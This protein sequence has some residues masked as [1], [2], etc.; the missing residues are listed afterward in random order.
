MR[1]WGPRSRRH[2]GGQPQTRAWVAVV[3][4]HLS[5]GFALAGF[6]NR[7]RFYLRRCGLC[8]TVWATYNDG[9]TRQFPPPTITLGRAG[10]GRSRTPPL[11][12][13]DRGLGARIL[14]PPPRR[15]LNRPTRPSRQGIRTGDLVKRE[16]FLYGEALFL[17]ATPKSNT[18]TGSIGSVL[19][20]SASNAV[21]A[22]NDRR[23]LSWAWY[24]RPEVRHG[25]SPTRARVGPHTRRPCDPLSPMRPMPKIQL[26]GPHPLSRERPHHDSKFYTKSSPPR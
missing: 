21:D 20:S 6:A 24:P 13:F 19:R 12:R 14:Q 16:H 4:S 25:G 26:S 8:R 5:C 10:G 9:I 23:C 1:W 22:N 7:G 2:A 18:H 15:V 11:T 3:S 17:P